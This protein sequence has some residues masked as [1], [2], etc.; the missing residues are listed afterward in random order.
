MYV[1]TAAAVHSRCQIIR[2]RGQRKRIVT[3]CHFELWQSWTRGRCV[4]VAWIQRVIWPEREFPHSVYLLCTFIA[5]V[6]TYII[7]VIQI[8]P[9]PYKSIKMHP[10][11]LICRGYTYIKSFIYVTYTMYI[12]TF[13]ETKYHDTISWFMLVNDDTISLFMPLN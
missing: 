4:W 7:V 3:T 1:C 13:K 2:P 12:Y 10:N 11:N 5:N 9:A 6:I 8:A